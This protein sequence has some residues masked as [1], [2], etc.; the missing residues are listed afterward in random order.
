MPALTLAA[1]AGDEQ[2]RAAGGLDQDV[3]TTRRCVRDVMTAGGLPADADIRGR[4]TRV[5]VGAGADVVAVTVVRGT[6]WMR[7]RISD[8][9][10]PHEVERVLRDVIGVTRLE[11]DVET[12]VG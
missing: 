10:T 6:V 7:L 11:L 1:G 2:V 8:P 12:G 5:A 9:A 4:V 3:R